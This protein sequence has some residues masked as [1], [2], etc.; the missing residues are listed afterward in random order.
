MEDKKKESS[1]PSNFEIYPNFIRFQELRVILSGTWLCPL[2]S[3]LHRLG[4]SSLSWRRACVCC[5]VSLAAYFLPMEFWEFSSLLSL[6]ANSVLGGPNWLYFCWLKI[7]K[8]LVFPCLSQ[9]FMPLDMRFFHELFL[10][11]PISNFGFCWNGWGR[12]PLKVTE[13]SLV[14]LRASVNHILNASKKS[15]SCEWIHCPFSCCHNKSLQCRGLKQP[16]L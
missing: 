15:L 6:N 10:V 16:S 3:S 9:E 13:G 2:G 5:W 4:H 11:D 8:H 14:W 7:L 1:V 12:M